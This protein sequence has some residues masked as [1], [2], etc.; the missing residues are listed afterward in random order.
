ML[1]A[2]TLQVAKA[3]SIHSGESR[4]STNDVIAAKTLPESPSRALFANLRAAFPT[5]PKGV[6]HPPFQSAGID[7]FPGG[8]GMC[9]QDAPFPFGGVMILGHNYGSDLDFSR[10]VRAAE[11]SWDRSVWHL[12]RNT[13]KALVRWGIDPATCFFTNFYP[14]YVTTRDR[15]GKPFN[16]GPHPHAGDAAFVRASR[17]FFVRQVRVQRPRAV[18]VLGAEV[19]PLLAPLDRRLRAWSPWPT[20]AALDASGGS[21]VRG[22]TLGGV[23][24]NMCIITHPSLPNAGHR[25]YGDLQGAKAED[26]M[27]R[28]TVEA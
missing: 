17:E 15:Y 8:T 4:M 27:V 9:V 10:N 28:A 14:G 25:R 6:S 21:M 13:Y 5:L 12:C 24:F 22:L 11:T 3:G 7:F 19:P 2:Q 23:T 18:L 20:F 16:V 26:A 1:I